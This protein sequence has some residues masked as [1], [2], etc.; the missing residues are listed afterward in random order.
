[1][2]FIELVTEADLIQKLN[3]DLVLKTLDYIKIIEDG[4]LRVVFLDGTEI[5]CR[6]EDV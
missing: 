1:M 2:V 3:T 4:A 5:E 6:S